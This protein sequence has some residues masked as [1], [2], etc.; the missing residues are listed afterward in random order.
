VVMPAMSGEVST[1]DS[2]RQGAQVT[3]SEGPNRTTTGTPKAAAMWAGPLSFPIKR[4]APEISLLVSLRDVCQCPK[5]SNGATSSVGPARKT[6]LMLSWRSWRATAMKRL[7]RPGLFGR[8]REGMD[9]GVCVGHLKLFGKEFGAGNL[10][11]RHSEPKH[12]GS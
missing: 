4:E 8:G 5:F 2:V 1:C 9:D 11:V 12:R 3:G 10:L 7:A 6:G